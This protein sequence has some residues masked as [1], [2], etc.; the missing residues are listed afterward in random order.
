MRLLVQ[1]HILIIGMILEL[2]C[3]VPV[4]Y[5]HLLGKTFFTNKT[6]FDSNHANYINITFGIQA[7]DNGEGATLSLIH[8]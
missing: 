5:T 7:T 1:V 4:S 2:L 6:T 8:I 3:I